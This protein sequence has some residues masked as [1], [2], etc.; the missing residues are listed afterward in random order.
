MYTRR[1][2]TSGSKVLLMKDIKGMSGMSKENE[3]NKHEELSL[4]LFIVMN[5]ALE[6]LRKQAT[7][8]VK[9]HGLNLTEFAVLELLY[10]KGPQPIQVI[11]KKVLLASSSITYV[12]DKLEEK[13]L[14]ERI[15][16][17]KDR[18]VINVTLTPSGEALIKQIFPEHRQ[19]ISE[20]FDSLSLEEKEV[21]ITLVKKIGIYAE[22]L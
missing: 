18:R 3:R 13:Q 14:I 20:L 19:A 7:E 11:G 12:I 10:H 1:H 22:N 15:A 5:R 9:R 16:C 4:K 8:D 17:P 6:E 21:A 2:H